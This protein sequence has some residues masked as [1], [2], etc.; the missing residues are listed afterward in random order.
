MALWDEARGEAADDVHLTVESGYRWAR[1]EIGHVHATAPDIGYS[2]IDLHEVERAA[3]GDAV[4]PARHVDV[5]AHSRCFTLGVRRWD[6]RRRSP[7]AAVKE[8]C[9]SYVCGA[10]EAG[11]HIEIVVSYCS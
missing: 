6:G 11:D 8:V 2:V 5:G 4:E 7:H 3:K 1:A 10:V 9:L